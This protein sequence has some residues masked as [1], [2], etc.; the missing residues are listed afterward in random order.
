M[1][2]VDLDLAE[3]L[4]PE[5]LGLRDDLLEGGVADLALGVCTGLVDGNEGD[6]DADV[7]LGRVAFVGEECAR[8]IYTTNEVASQVERGLAEALRIEELAK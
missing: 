2:E 1:L 3:L 6:T 8:F 5:R 4:V 7:Y